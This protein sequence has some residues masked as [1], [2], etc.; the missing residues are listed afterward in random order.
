M[1]IE[2][3]RTNPTAH[4]LSAIGAVILRFGLVVPLAWIGIQKFTSDEA[5]AIMPLITHQPLMSW[6]YEV[7]SVQTLSNALGAVEITAAILIAVRPLSPTASALGSGIALLLFVSTISFLFT[8]PG[9]VAPSSLGLPVLTETG[10][11][12]IKDIVLLG[13]AVWTLGDALQA[14]ASTQVSH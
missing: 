7:L 9:I 11:F 14:R 1:T 13:A 4:A 6:L 8:T 3:T 5:N 10:G 2:E 12:L